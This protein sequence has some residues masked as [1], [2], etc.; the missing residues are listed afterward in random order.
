M[1]LSAKVIAVVRIYHGGSE[2]VKL[3]YMFIFD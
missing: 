2:T 3:I 1:I